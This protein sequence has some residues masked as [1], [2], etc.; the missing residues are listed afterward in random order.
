MSNSKSIQVI[1]LIDDDFSDSERGEKE[2]QKSNQ[3]LRSCK[4]R[5]RRDDDI[6]K[7]L[8]GEAECTDD[9]DDME[10]EDHDS[11]ADS[12]GNLRDFVV[13]DSLADLLAEYDSDDSDDDPDFLVNDFEENKKIC[14]TK[15]KLI[16][17]ISSA[18]DEVLEDDDLEDIEQPIKRTK[19]L[20]KPNVKYGNQ[21]HRIEPTT[22]DDEECETLSD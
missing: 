9:E 16:D 7:Y 20:I 3:D 14:T 1:E 4:K 2:Q 5:K 21:I 13:E 6:L 22:D 18:L 8:Y 17:C 19:Y 11:D 12:Q 15:R 10:D